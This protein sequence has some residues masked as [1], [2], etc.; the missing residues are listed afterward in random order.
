MPS[1]PP[2]AGLDAKSPARRSSRSP[3]RS[4]GP[5]S[6]RN[7]PSEVSDYTSEGVKNNDIF[8]LPKSDYKIVLVITALATLVRL[9][10]IYQPTSVVFDEVQLV[11]PILPHTFLHFKALSLQLITTVVLADSRRSILRASSSWT[12]IPHWLSCLSPSPGIL[13]DSGAISISRRLAKIIWS[14]EFPMLRCACFRRFLGFYP[15]LLC[16]SH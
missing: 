3:G 13:V 10:R 2:K 4:P 7:A 14:P 1:R 6:R 12:C 5:K 11:Y 9:F 16:F 15:S 8:G